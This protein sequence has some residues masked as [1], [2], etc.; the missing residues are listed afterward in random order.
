MARRKD[1]KRTFIMYADIE[2]QLQDFSDAEAG[3]ILKAILA[4]ANR[5]EEPSLEDRA[6]R[7]LFKNIKSTIDRTDEAYEQKCETNRRI[8]EERERKRREAREVQTNT[9]EHERA[10]TETNVHDGHPSHLNSSHLNSTHLISLS[11]E[12]KETAPE[13]GTDEREREK[14]RDG[15]NLEE[16]KKIDFGSFMECFKY[17]AKQNNS[18]IS[19]PK[20]MTEQRKQKLQHLLDAGYTKK[21]MMQVMNV[22]T[23]SPKLNGRTK[24]G[25]IPDFDWIFDEKNFVRIL[26]GNFNNK[27]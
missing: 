1:D 21:E 3:Q 14:E 11:K 2:D 15:E 26:E 5:G 10:R 4:Y 23:A 17:Y 22:A 24:K 9:N 19:C 27:E 12:N 18:K 25:F 13:P 7:C 6:L 20:H 16:E 8:A